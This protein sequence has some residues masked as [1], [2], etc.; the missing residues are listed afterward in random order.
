MYQ[1]K[2]IDTDEHG[3][4]KC[5]IATGLY[6]DFRKAFADVIG[7]SSM[8]EYAEEYGKGDYMPSKPSH[9]H[10]ASETHDGKPDDFSFKYPNGIVI[11]IEEAVIKDM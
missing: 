6:N 4:Q 3:R 5:I 2:I 7:E 9:I 11:T 8:Y 10:Y 1:V